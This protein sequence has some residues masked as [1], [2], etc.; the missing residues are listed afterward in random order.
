MAAVSLTMSK[1][2]VVIVISILASSAIS[3]GTSMM[4]ASVSRG[5]EG[6][7]G[8][9]GPQGQKGATGNTGP[10][11]PQGLTGPIGA[12][13]TTGSTGPQGPQGSQ[14]PQ[15][16]QGVQGLT[17]PMGATGPPGEKGDTGATG[18]TGTQGEQGVP[19]LGVQPGFVVAPAYD[20][21]WVAVNGGSRRFVHGLGTTD[22]VV[23]LR[24]YNPFSSNGTAPGIDQTGLSWYNLTTNDVFVESSLLTQTHWIRVM[25]WR[26]TPP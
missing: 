4:L 26:I 21:G 16:A 20:S 22:V 3:V 18:A 7:Q 9:I 23:E 25:M 13:G 17:G 2:I 24:R 11:G 15:G 10:Q 19:G 8:D 14:G 1:L 12:T 6:L 5:P